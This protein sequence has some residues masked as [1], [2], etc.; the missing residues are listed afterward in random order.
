LQKTPINLQYL[1][2]SGNWVSI[3]KGLGSGAKPSFTFQ[4]DG[5]GNQK[6][7][8]QSEGLK[9]AY[10]VFSSNVSTVGFTAAKSK[11]SKS[12][13]D[14]G[15][16]SVPKGAVDKKSNSYKL[17]FNFGGNVAAGSL[18]TDSALAQCIS[19]KNSG[20]VRVRG[21]PQY[22]G[23]QAVQIQSYLNTASGFQG[24]LDGFGK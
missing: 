23:V 15:S 5:L 2:S 19:A 20:V 11:S 6:L 14:L 10:S 13:T 3:S 17:M 12:S 22:L 8:I 9:D 24:C 4:L 16:S 7:R 18:A 1:N 21:I